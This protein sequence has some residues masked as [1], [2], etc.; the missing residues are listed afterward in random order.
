MARQMVTRR[1]KANETEPAEKV[2]DEETTPREGRRGSRSSRVA[3]TAKATAGSGWG[4][5]AKAK[6]NQKKKQFFDGRFNVE[7]DTEY[8]IRFLEDGPIDTYYQHFVPRAKGKKRS[9]TCPGETVCDPCGLDDFPRLLAVFNIAVYNDKDAKWEQ[10]YWEAAKVAEDI[11]D[12]ANGKMRVEALNADGQYFIVS[13]EEANYGY[14]YDLAP[15]SGSTL[16]D[17]ELLNFAIEE[18]F[19]ENL[20]TTDVI[21]KVD[22]QWLKEVAEELVAKGD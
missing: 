10:K 5:Y 21:D 19:L 20:F 15:I 18:E 8:L 2:L 16:K 3:E 7:A 4:A 9:G 1:G 13:K 6:Q 22:A 17:D 14:T 12:F 11:E